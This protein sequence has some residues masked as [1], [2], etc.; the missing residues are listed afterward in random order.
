MKVY[1]ILD[2]GKPMETGMKRTRKP[3]PPEV[4][5]PVQPVWYKYNFPVTDFIV[6]PGTKRRM[7]KPY[8]WTPS[9]PFYFGGK[10]YVPLYPCIAFE[11]RNFGWIIQKGPYGTILGRE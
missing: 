11:T 3:L 9:K 7:A 10:R 1:L 4:Y 6:F 2:D 5:G 8:C